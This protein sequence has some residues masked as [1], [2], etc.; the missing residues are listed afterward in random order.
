M[1]IECC[2]SCGSTNI[3]YNQS[4][5]PTGDP[6]I[7]TCLNCMFTW[8]Y[9]PPMIVLS[10]EIGELKKAVDLMGDNVKA[11]HEN[12]AKTKEAVNSELQKIN[13][14]MKGVRE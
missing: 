13:E 14:L 4:D 2:A 1:L 10:K 12:M 11:N 7:C 5:T 8:F 3:M 9:S 6:I